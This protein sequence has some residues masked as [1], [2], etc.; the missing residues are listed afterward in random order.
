MA[1]RELIVFQHNSELGC[2]P[3]WKLFEAVKVERVT[4]PDDPA[5]SYQDYAVTVDEAALPA[6]VTCIRMS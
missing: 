5:R 3:A 4:N 6:G 1:V 2:A